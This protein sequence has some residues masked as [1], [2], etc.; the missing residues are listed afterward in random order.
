MHEGKYFE[1]SLD[2]NLQKLGFTKVSIFGKNIIV[3][4][5]GRDPVVSTYRKDEWERT[6]KSLEKK[7][8]AEGVEPK[9]ARE[10]IV[11]MTRNS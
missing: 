1:T 2:D 3:G 10:I 8:A 9:S 11:F 4:I 7:L 6:A 5:Q